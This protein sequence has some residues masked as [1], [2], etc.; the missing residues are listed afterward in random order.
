MAG[1]GDYHAAGVFQA[2]RVDAR[3]GGSTAGGQSTLPLWRQQVLL[4]PAV[5][6]ERSIASV[7]AAKP[8][9]AALDHYQLAGNVLLLKLGIHFL[10]MF[11][12]H[13]QILVAV[14]QECGGSA[15]RDSQ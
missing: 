12:G 6:G 7:D 2:Y 3:I 4:E 1:A 13:A 9:A 10:A 15:G 8:V 5:S 11:Q 14:D